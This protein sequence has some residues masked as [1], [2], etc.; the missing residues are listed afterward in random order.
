MTAGETALI[1]KLPEA[2]PLV[3]AWRDRYDSSAAAGV[4]A[5]VTVLYPFLHESRLDADVVN[6]L[7]ELI[8]AHDPFE[9]RFTHCGRFP[10]VLYLAPDPDAPFR[11]LTE[12]VA[13]RWP[14]AP[15]HGGQFE[16][17]VPHL[18]VAHGQDP[19]TYDAIEAALSGTA[20]LSACVTAVHLFVRD[21]AEHWH[22]RRAFALGRRH[23]TAVSAPAVPTAVSR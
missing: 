5:H 7:V 8:G 10:D 9:V 17:V 12:A 21:G 4:P 1:V 16:D 22:E 6:T 14:E 20:P 13:A 19:A 2:E 15:P 11:A 23:H 18:T 3:D